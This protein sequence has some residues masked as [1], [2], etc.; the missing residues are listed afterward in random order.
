MLLEA[1]VGADGRTRDLTV[2]RG[3]PL[4]MTEAALAA[5][6][7]WRYQPATLDGQPV[8]VKLVVAVRF[9]LNEDKPGAP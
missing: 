1:V 9:N 8:A 4:G 3:M 5:A 7:Q 6:R 2:L